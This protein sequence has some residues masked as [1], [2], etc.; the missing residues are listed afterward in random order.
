LRHLVDELSGAAAERNGCAVAAEHGRRGAWQ[1]EEKE[2]KLVEGAVGGDDDPLDL[3]KR[4]GPDDSV[5]SC[6][7]MI[8]G[9]GI[10]KFTQN[11]N[12]FQNS[13]SHAW[14]NKYR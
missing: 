4:L 8:L 12:T 9:E 11:P 3:E 7:S 5:E 6:V 13:S 10:V 1:R 2:S 14:S